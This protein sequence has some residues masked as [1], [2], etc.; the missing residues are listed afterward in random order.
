[1]KRYFPIVLSAIVVAALGFY[2]VSKKQTIQNHDIE[3]TEHT[4]I[5]SF[6]PRRTCSVPP[7]F[8]HKL[9]IPQP[10]IIDLSQKRYKGIALLY[11]E[12]FRQTLH[13]KQ[14]EQ[15]EHFSTYTLDERGNIYL[16]PTPF[17]SIRPTTFNLQKKIYKLDT[18]TSKISIWMDMDDVHP[19][20]HNPYGINAVA[21]DCDDKSLWVSAI[22][23]SDYKS[24]KGVIYH[25]NSSKKEVL[26]KVEGFDAL[27]LAL[28]HTD[29]GKYLLAGSARDNGLYALEIVKGKL[30]DKPMRVLEIPDPNE[31]IRRI[32]IKGKNHLELQTIPFTYSMIAR[33]A[34][35]DRTHFDAVLD[36]IHNVWEVKMMQ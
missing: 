16:A 19:S 15:F 29:K 35:K 21:Y 17:I 2:V 25:I 1:M 22:D 11:G 12:G 14:W 6:S 10:V 3:K 5:G 33:T 23:E 34:K 20:E 36:P 28:L 7:L 27:T 4:D 24:Q 26:Q 13:P 18:K 30:S 9:H 31:H 8:L 32:K